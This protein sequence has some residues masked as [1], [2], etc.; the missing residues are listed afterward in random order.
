MTGVAHES[1]STQIVLP[2]MFSRDLEQRVEILR[3]ALPAHDALEDRR[4]PRRAFAALRALRAAL[5]REEAR[6]RARSASRGTA[7]RRSRS[8]RPSRASCRWRR[9]PRSPSSVASAS[10]IV[11]IGTEDA[12]G[13]DRLELSARQRPAAEVVQE[14]LERKSHRD[15]VVARPRDVAAHREE[16]R[17]RALRVVERDR[18]PCTSRRR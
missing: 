14:I 2:V 16:L 18:S 5:V 15:F 6:E 4:R 11:W 12:A 10:S 1:L 13:D 7:R 3:R 9:I 17:A 8:R